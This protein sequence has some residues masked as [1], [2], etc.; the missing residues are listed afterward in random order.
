MMSRRDLLVRSAGASVGSGILSLGVPA[1]GL[2]RQAAAAAEPRADLPILV[3]VELTG[4]ND[5]LNTIVPYADDLYHKNRP[6]L[7]IE[8]DKVLKL[9]DHVGVHPSLKELHALWELGDLAVIQGV[10]YPNPNRSHTRSMEIWQTGVV[11]TAPPAGW[12]G[13]VADADSTFRLCHVGPE[14]VPLAVRGRTAIPQAL[15]SLADYQ[16]T[17][18]ARLPALPQDEQAGGAL[19]RRDP[20]AVSYQPGIWQRVWRRCRRARQ[21]PLPPRYPRHWRVDWRRFG[22]SSRPIWR[23]VSI[24]QPRVALTHMPPSVLFTR[25]CCAR[26][27]KPLLDFSRP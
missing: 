4:G 1:S 20:Q 17:A 27:R 10:G 23:C 8:P 7:R 18:N 22:D 25:V 13:R 5:G 9:D 19:S 11:G 24:T 6:T 15:A 16:L 14:T 26:S 21:F 12:L 2:W 3:V